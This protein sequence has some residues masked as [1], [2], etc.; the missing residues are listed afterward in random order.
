MFTFNFLKNANTLIIKHVIKRGVRKRVRHVKAGKRSRRTTVH[1]QAKRGEYIEFKEPARLLA[2]QYL[3]IYVKKYADLGIIIDPYKKVFIKNTVSRWGSCS[4]KKNLN[5]SYRL[6]TIPPHLA[7][8]IVVHELCHLREFNHAK[9]FWDL[10]ALTIP[11]YEE[12]KE[13]L[14]KLSLR[15]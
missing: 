4:S 8:Y 11:D 15:R 2:H 1:L 3:E 12:R 13:E 6:A 10:V 14:R 7:E 5:F 9:S